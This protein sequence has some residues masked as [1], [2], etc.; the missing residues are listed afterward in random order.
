MKTMIQS[1]SRTFAT[2]SM[3]AMAFTQSVFAEQPFGET[4]DIGTPD[5]ADGESIRSTITDVL[6]AVLSFLALIAVVV[7][8]I[9][10]IR[11]II[12]QGEDE[13]KDKAKKTIFYALIGLIV[14]LFARVIV[15]LVTGFL[16]D[17]VQG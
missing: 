8:V 12:S 5:A 6:K 10:G 4:P 13:Q 16:A 1:L 15:S 7:I 2:A 11:L 14:I 3:T 9:A 17:E